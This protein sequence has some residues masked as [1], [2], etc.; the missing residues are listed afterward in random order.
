MRKRQRN[1]KCEYT[2]CIEIYINLSEKYF[3]IENFEI[4]MFFPKKF[5]LF[6]SKKNANDKLMKK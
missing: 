3:L 2:S 6:L 5:Y 1:I 4:T